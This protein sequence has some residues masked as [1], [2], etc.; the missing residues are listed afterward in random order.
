MPQP[1]KFTVTTVQGA[2]LASARSTGARPRAA[3]RA[4]SNE[5]RL[6]RHPATFPLKLMP[7]I[8]SF[9]RSP[10]IAL[11]VMCSFIVGFHVFGSRT[12]AVNVSGAG[13]VNGPTH[14]ILIPSR[15]LGHRQAYKIRIIFSFRGLP[16]SA[17]S[18]L[19]K[20]N[21]CLTQSYPAICEQRAATAPCCGRATQRVGDV[22]IKP[23]PK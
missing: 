13:R 6:P 15:A 23:G 7:Q 1:R 17:T 18:S 11:R 21:S 20:T 22:I 19:I 3:F 4:P 2:R 5:I 12:S 10:Q 9:R 14:M 16:A 8:I